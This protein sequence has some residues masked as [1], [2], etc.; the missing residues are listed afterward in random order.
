MSAVPGAGGGGGA[1]FVIK[2]EGGIV[3]G[4][5]K[6]KRVNYGRK[7]RKR[8]WGFGISIYDPKLHPRTTYYVL[9]LLVTSTHYPPAS[10]LLRSRYFIPPLK[11]NQVLPTYLPTYLVFE[12]NR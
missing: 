2:K 6:P 7:I 3:G 4:R 12:V 1:F 9:L 10:C 5:R 11:K 8:G